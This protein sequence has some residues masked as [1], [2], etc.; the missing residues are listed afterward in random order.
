LG[1][2]PAT[3]I[4]PPGLAGYTSAEGFVP[5]VAKAR[6]LLAEAGFPGGRGMPRLTI[7]YNTSEG[8]RSIAEVIQQQLQNNLNI[9]I[10]LQNM[11]W[12]SFLDK[13]QQT[14]Y[15]IA[16]AGWIAD[17]PDPN[18]FLDMWMTG[19]PQN[20]TNWSNK[21][22]DELI[23]SAARATD[24]AQRMDLLRQAE[25]IFIDELPVIPIYFYTSINVVKPNV[26]GF[27]PS[28]QDLHPLQLLRFD[29][30]NAD[31]K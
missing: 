28:A 13:V 2:L 15:Q 17:Y 29:D 22:Y 11:E 27:F 12:G 1:Q 18:T 7:L 5:D 16:R 19:N 10:E 4:V 24:P 14:D 25:Q 30:S 20:N 26:K 23:R 21:E 31:R 3:T 9:A 6:E 8:H